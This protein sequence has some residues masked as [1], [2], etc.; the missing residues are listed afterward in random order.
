LAAEIGADQ[1]PVLPHAMPKNLLAHSEGLGAG[2]LLC[3]KIARCRTQKYGGADHPAHPPIL[4]ARPDAWS[5]RTHGPTWIAISFKDPVTITYVS[6]WVDQSPE[7]GLRTD[8]VSVTFDSG[9]E[10][11]IEVWVGKRKEGDHWE[12]KFK[13]V[14]NV[15]RL[16]IKTYYIQNSWVGWSYVEVFGK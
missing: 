9:L 16:K 10:L 3:H 4:K 14:S 7:P 1:E 15:K 13:P 2:H 11:P 6:V 8:L 12:S 5:S